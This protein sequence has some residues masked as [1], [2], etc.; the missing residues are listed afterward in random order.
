MSEFL[1]PTDGL[2]VQA[3]LSSIFYYADAASLMQL[4]FLAIVVRM[5]ATYLPA[6]PTLKPALIAGGIILPLYFFH[7]FTFADDFGQLLDTFLRSVASL[8]IASSGAA[9]ITTAVSPI[10]RRLKDLREGRAMRKKKE[11]E[12][13]LKQE[14]LRLQAEADA[15]RPPPPPPPLP[16]SYQDRLKA[17]ADAAHAEHDAEI[18]MLKSL[19]LD[20]DEFEVLEMDA[21]RKLLRKL[22]ERK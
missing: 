21:K 11:A 22:R 15:N 1:V 20:Q 5:S 18:A 8:V 16:L 3:A 17:F 2:A 12:E 7:R 9:I 4:I 14:L 6:P 19:P 10:F 13:E